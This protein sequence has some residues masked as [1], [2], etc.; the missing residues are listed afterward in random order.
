MCL[1]CVISKKPIIS[2][3]KKVYLFVCLLGNYSKK[4]FINEK[5]TSFLGNL[6]GWGEI[7]RERLELGEMS[8]ASVS[9]QVGSVQSRRSLSKQL[10]GSPGPLSCW[11]SG[12]GGTKTELERRLTVRSRICTLEKG[13]ALISAS[14]LDGDRPL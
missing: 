6:V 7:L 11:D 14:Q 1:C 3:E 8:N 2:T 12:A 10:L 5:G 4:H 9:R 13:S